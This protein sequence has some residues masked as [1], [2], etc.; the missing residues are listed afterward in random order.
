M[1][2]ASGYD[3]RMVLGLLP[4]IAPWPCAC[5]AQPATRPLTPAAPHLAFC[6]NHRGPGEVTFEAMDAVLEGV[7]RQLAGRGRKGG[8]VFLDLGS[9]S[10]KAVVAASL[11]GD[12]SRTVG[13][14]IIDELHVLSIDMASTLRQL[15]FEEACAPATAMVSEESV[16]PHKGDV[17]LSYIHG[18]F[19]SEPW[20]KG[21]SVVLANS[22]CFGAGLLRVIG[23]LAWE[24]GATVIVT[25]TE[26]LQ[27]Y[28]TCAWEVAE[29]LT[30]VMSWG[31]AT[32]FVHRLVDATTQT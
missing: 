23:E 9:G 16:H 5:N 22:T 31:S 10:G 15:L 28:T 27:M 30:L 1:T 14:E 26:P 32:V 12:F 7:A 24:A 19:T 20:P 18:D 4:G 25:F 11:L 8:G 2:C 6:V 29:T 17:D 13:I 21:V 3:P